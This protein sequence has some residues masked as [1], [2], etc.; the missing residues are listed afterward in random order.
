[1]KKQIFSAIILAAF[2]NFASAQS[3]GVFEIT[4]SVVANGGGNSSGG[5][6]SL[7]GT[8]GQ[9]VTEN[10]GQLTFVVQ[11]GFWQ[12]FTTVTAANVSVSGKVKTSDGR[13]LNNAVVLLTDTNGNSLS[14]KTGSFGFYRFD[15][16]EAGQT[17]ILTVISKH[18]LFQQQIVTLNESLSDI[19]FL[20]IGGNNS[21][22]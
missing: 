15:G 11:S 6:F 14:T 7:E 5:N 2:V 4:Q 17:V 3:G 19:D 12:S 20:P 9:T 22:K 8:I 21:L 10:S 13:G 1:M 18:F 16:I